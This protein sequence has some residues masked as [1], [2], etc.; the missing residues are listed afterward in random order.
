[1]LDGLRD[2]VNQKG[3]QHVIQLPGMTK[4]PWRSLAAMDIFVLTSRMEGLPN[5][6]VEAQ[7][8]GCPVVTPGLG[9]MSETYLEGTTGLTAGGGTAAELAQGVLTLL[10][11][12]SLHRDMANAAVLHARS[13]FGLSIDSGNAMCLLRC[14]RTCHGRL[15]QS[16]ATDGW[17]H[18]FSIAGRSGYHEVST[19]IAM[20]EGACCSFA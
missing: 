18:A 3:L 16:K 1:M 6:L 5:V 4:Q 20:G 11:N 14:A 10:E 17:S 9:G 12:R 8:A 2:N 7:A 13:R 19:S 15:P